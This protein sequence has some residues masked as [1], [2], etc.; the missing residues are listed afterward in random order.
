MMLDKLKKFDLVSLFETFS[1]WFLIIIISSYIF[2]S[3]IAID[4]SNLPKGFELP[5]ADFLSKGGLVIFSV[6]I[7]FKFINIG[8]LVYRNKN[9]DFIKQ[10]KPWVEFI[11]LGL[12]SFILLFSAVVSPYSDMAIYGNEWRTQGVLTY[13]PI[14][15]VGYVIYKTVSKNSSILIAL[16]IVI[17][18]LMQSV[19]AFEQFKSYY[20]SDIDKIS[21]GIWVNGYYGQSNFFST[22]LVLSILLIFA[23]LNSKYIVSISNKVLKA[24][25][26]ILFFQIGA[27]IILATIFSFSMWGWASLIVLAIVLLSYFLINKKRNFAIIFIIG[28]IVTIFVWLTVINF[29]PQ[30]N[31]RIHII[32]SSKNIFL[33]N[34]SN[35]FEGIKNNLIGYGFDTIGEV[36]RSFEQFPTVYIDRGHNIFVDLIM[37][38]GVFLFGIFMVFVLNI[39]RK[40][41]SI[42]TDPYTFI[43]F[44]SVA[45]WIFKTIVNEYSIVNV[46]QFVILLAVTSSL[47]PKKSELNN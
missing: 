14:F 16:A 19:K 11:I 31:L 26:N 15:L 35:G 40:I 33:G 13:L 12:C 21:E 22:H 5:K 45:L 34:F 41:F 46:A 36:F 2:L 44:F 37:Q 23:I 10:T 20:V 24:L 42:V 17:S 39:Y 27:I 25:I 1:N 47:L 18:G 32:N 8:L 38:G 43:F 9:F 4:Y 28:S 30:Y 29:Y 6:F 7:I 3:S